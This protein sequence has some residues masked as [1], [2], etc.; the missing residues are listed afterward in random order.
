[1]QMLAKH[2]FSP[3]EAGRISYSQTSHTARVMTR[4]GTCTIYD[5]DR[6]GPEYIKTHLSGLGVCGTNPKLRERRVMD[7]LTSHRHLL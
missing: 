4:M 6:Y 2:Y 3:Q 5:M 7:G 1:M